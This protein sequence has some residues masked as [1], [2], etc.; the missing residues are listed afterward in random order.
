MYAEYVWRGPYHNASTWQRVTDPDAAHSGARAFLPNPVN[1]ITLA[2]LDGAIAAEVMI[3]QWGGHT[4]TTD[5]AL[6]LNGSPWISVAH[7]EAIPGDRGSQRFTGPECYQYFTYSTT[8]VPLELLLTGENDFEFTSGDQACL[9]FG[10]GQ[11]GVYSV[12][13]RIY[14]DEQK[15]HPTGRIVSPGSGASVRDSLQLEA[16]ASSPNGEIVSV[17]FIGHY[18]DYDYD[19]DGIW[20]DWHHIYQNGHLKRQLGTAAEAPYRAQ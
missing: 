19:G 13:F 7:P 18:E 4:G 6:R 20:R 1:H 2:D 15:P 16:I 14:Y 9:G 12:I 17:D 8:S 5:K 11:W 3:Q 10:W